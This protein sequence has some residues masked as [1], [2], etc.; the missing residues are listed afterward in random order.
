M[1]KLLV[2]LV[3]LAIISFFLQEF[4]EAL[5]LT[6][7]VVFAFF[8]FLGMVFFFQ[9]LTSN[10]TEQLIVG[11]AMAVFSAFYILVAYLRTKKKE[12]N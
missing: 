6:T 4:I 5:F 2:F 7:L 8:F 11:L 10:D 1:A 9:G 12:K 3:A